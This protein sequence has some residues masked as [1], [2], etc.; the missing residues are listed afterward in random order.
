VTPTGQ[1]P[2]RLE[3]GDVAVLPDILGKVCTSLTAAV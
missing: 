1:N 2:T 3:L